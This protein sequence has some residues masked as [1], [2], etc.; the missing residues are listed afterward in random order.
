[1]KHAF[2][3]IYPFCPRMEIIQELSQCVTTE[4]SASSK[5][6]YDYEP[7]GSF[8][9]TVNGKVPFSQLLLQN[10]RLTN[11]LNVFTLKGKPGTYKGE[12]KNMGYSETNH[13]IQGS[14]EAGIKL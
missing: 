5:P 10:H 14:T 8:S 1:M 4:S 12:M 11:N 2:L 7:D 6:G 3:E 9:I 13:T